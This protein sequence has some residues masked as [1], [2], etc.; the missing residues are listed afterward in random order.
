MCRSETAL[1]E[2]LDISVQVF[3]LETATRAVCWCLVFFRRDCFG[4]FIISLVVKTWES[5]EDIIRSSNSIKAPGRDNRLL[6]MN[7]LPNKERKALSNKV[8][9]KFN[10]VT[11]NVVYIF[12][13]ICVLSENTEQNHSFVENF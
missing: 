3:C 2:T 11:C 5:G 7:V 10:R 12:I 9:V 1:R 13:W 8:R 4:G 6:E